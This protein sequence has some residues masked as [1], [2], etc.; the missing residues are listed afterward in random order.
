ME[1]AL[2]RAIQDE[3][4]AEQRELLRRYIERVLPQ[5]VG[6]IFALN[7][8]GEEKLVRVERAGRNA[9]GEDLYRVVE[10]PSGSPRE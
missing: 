8:D 4:E 1:E 10:L 6:R 3:V 5:M 9:L 7:V 2:F